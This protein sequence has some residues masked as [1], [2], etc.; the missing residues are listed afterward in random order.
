MGIAEADTDTLLA[1]RRN[2]LRG[3]DWVAEHAATGTLH[4]VPAGRSTPPAASGWLVVILLELVD[5]ELAARVPVAAV[6]AR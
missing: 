5:A 2:L 6:P 1:L 3:L 4:T